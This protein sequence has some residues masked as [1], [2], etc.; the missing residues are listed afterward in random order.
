MPPPKL[1][2]APLLRVAP[3]FRDLVVLLPLRVAAEPPVVPVELLPRVV[4]PLAP[5]APYVA[6]AEGLR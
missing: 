3:E 2:P 4:M 6:P 5:P 1:M